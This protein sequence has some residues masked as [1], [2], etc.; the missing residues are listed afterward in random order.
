MFWSNELLLSIGAVMEY[1]LLMTRVMVIGNAGGGKST[2]CRALSSG[3]SLPYY[4]ID[5]IQ[6]RPNWVPTPEPEF[7]QAHE[8]LLSKERWLID[9]YGSWSSVERRI[10]MADTIVFVDH[11]IW[12]HYWWATKRQIKSL[13]YGRSDGPEGCPMFPVTIRLF[14]MMWWLHREK[15]PELIAAIDA[16]RGKARLIHIRSPRQ[17]AAFTAN[18]V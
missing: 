13:F 16:R 8:A 3:H 14:R 11:P 10:S 2:M 5:K 18:P 1:I 17:L 6:W 4:A 9:G 7:T 12:V 15:R